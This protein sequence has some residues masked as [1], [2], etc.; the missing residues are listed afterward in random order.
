MS[1]K[2]YRGLKDALEL[3]EKLDGRS[4]F[5]WFLDAARGVMDV[6]QTEM[7]KILGV[8]R[9]MVCDIEKGRQFVSPTLALKIA[10]KAGLSPREALR[11]CF[12]DQLRKAKIKYEVDIKAA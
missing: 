8:S 12:Q 10:N 3:H 9:S 1:T 11:L 5:G 4:H 2:K 6:T 7:A